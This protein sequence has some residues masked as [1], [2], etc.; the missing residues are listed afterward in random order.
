[1]SNTGILQGAHDIVL[2]NPHLNDNSIRVE[3]QTIHNT[4]T[5]KKRP[6][7]KKLLNASM[8][9]AFYDS[10]ARDPPPSCHPGTRFDF[11]DAITGWGLGASQQTERILWMYGPAG[12]GKSA[13][14]QSCAEL[15]AE[16]S[17][18][19]AA[20][21]FSRSV[22]LN[23][24]DDPHRLFT[25]LS[26]QIATKSKPF[27]DILN[28]NI[29]NDPTLVTK[30]IREQFQELLVKPLSQLEL[31]TAG[32]VEGLVIIIDGLDECG[33]GP[34]MHCDVVEIIVASV[35]NR[36]TPFR[37][38]ILSRPETHIVGSFTRN[39]T[40]TISYHL[41]IRVSRDIDNE[42]TLYLTAELGK[43]QQRS[44]LPDSWLSE[45][46]VGVFVNLSAGLFIYAATVIRFVGNHKSLGPVDQLRAVLALANRDKET[47]PVH[48]LSELD[49]FYTLIVHCIP[50]EILPRIYAIL[51]L[52]VLARETNLQSY[53]NYKQPVMTVIIANILG[54]SE[55]QFRSACGSLHSVLELDSQL[56]IIFYHASFMDFLEDSKRSGEFCI[57]SC[58]GSLR[59][60]LLQ[61]L[62][63]IHA[64]S[65]GSSDVLISVDIVWPDPDLDNTGVYHRLV[66]MFFCLCQWQ[67]HPLDRSTSKALLDFQFH[68][69]PLLWP[70]GYFGSFA[71]HPSSLKKNICADFRDQIIRKTY[72]PTVYLSKP[73]LAVWSKLY[74]LGYGKNKVLFWKN[75]YNYW[76]LSPYPTLF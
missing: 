53:K 31:D 54:L 14:A 11:I 32:G 41:E 19:G 65:I 48:P 27:G 50:S 44:G 1:M 29:Q 35:R 71:L 24:R 38:V 39:N 37:W 20:L 2:N 76:Y 17:K 15:L 34:E 72:N 61:R 67:G 46:D 30:S 3:N 74:V 52:L 49:F 68:L 45:R 13:V 66:D 28:H 70:H 57:Y 55:P 43:I 56:E 12:V 58:L 16:K 10:S 6:G 69:I 4:I 7:L 60:K 75:E 40:R 23:K 73:S 8:P 9:D 25:S 42:I 59:L 5:D 33:G 62:N 51:L 22:G 47:G 64:G 63:G 18:L 21:F 26:Y 36:T